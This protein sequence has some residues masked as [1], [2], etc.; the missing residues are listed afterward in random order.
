M[1]NYLSDLAARVRAA[2]PSEAE[3]PADTDDL[4]VLYAILVRVKGT[5]TS[6]SDV[7]DAWSGWIIQKGMQ[8][9]SLVPFDQLDA[10]TKSEDSPYLAAIHKVAHDLDK[11]T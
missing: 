1:S 6:L 4:F 10:S 5:Q 7:H 3:P 9:K 11:N 2:V 8:H